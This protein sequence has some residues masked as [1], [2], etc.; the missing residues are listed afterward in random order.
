LVGEEELEDIP[1]KDEEE[2]VV[3]EGDELC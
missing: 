2:E 3:D 1:V